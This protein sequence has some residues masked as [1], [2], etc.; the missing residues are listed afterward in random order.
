VI[1][2]DLPAPVRER[3]RTHARIVAPGENA[4]IPEGR[5]SVRYTLGV[6]QRVGPF[7]RLDLDSRGVTYQEGR[8]PRAHAGGWTLYL[9]ETADGWVEVSRDFWIS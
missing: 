8:P 4:G 2:A 7:V 3:W 1:D 6:V 9:L 5:S